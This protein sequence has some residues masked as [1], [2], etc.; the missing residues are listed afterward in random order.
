[1][2]TSLDDVIE[3]ARVH[4]MTGV[5]NSRRDLEATFEA[6]QLA[7]F[8]RADLDVFSNSNLVEVRVDSVVAAAKQP[9]IPRTTEEP[10]IMSEDVTAA[11]AVIAAVLGTICALATVSWVLSSGGDSASAVVAAVV[12]GVA[13]GGIGYLATP[14]LLRT[15]EVVT[16]TGG[17]LRFHIAC[18]RLVARS[19]ANGPANSSR[20]RRKHYQGPRY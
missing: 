10:V 6:L 17:C 2:R 19:R 11:R 4:E 5:F 1:M 12:A 14:G 13:A 8:N 18:A 7:G 9:A 20:T 3:R 15:N 16:R